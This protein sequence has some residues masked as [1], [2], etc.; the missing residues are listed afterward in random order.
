MFR[1]PLFFVARMAGCGRGGIMTQRFAAKVSGILLLAGFVANVNA[2]TIVCSGT[3]EAL[4]FHASNTGGLLMIRLSSMNTPVYFCD[5]ENAWSAPGSG[6]AVSPATCRALYAT[7][8]SA[9]VSGTPISG[10]YFDGDSAPADC[11][12]WGGWQSANIRH[13]TF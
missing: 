9:R 12:A 2:A 3:V 13:Y 10:M 7:F 11:N 1:A 5:P 6:Y 4:S 8:L